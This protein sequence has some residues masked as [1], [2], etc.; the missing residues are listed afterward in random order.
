MGSN[1]GG[2]EYKMVK[3]LFWILMAAFSICSCGVKR[4]PAP[5][6]SIPKNNFES[7]STN[8]NTTPTPLKK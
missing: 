8:P 2:S 7:I 1:H 4:E 3:T 5:L 6:Y